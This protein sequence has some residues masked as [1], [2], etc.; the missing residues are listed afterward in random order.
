MEIKTF[1]I[2]GLKL[3]RL[4][5]FKDAR[6]FFVERYNQT[7]FQAAGLPMNFV[8]DNFSRSAPGVLRGLHFQH[9]PAQGKLVSCTSGRIFDVAVDVRKDSKT[10]GQHVTVE[11]DGAEPML[12]WIPAG[13]AHGF[14]VMGDQPA[15]VLYKVDNLWSA[16]GEGCLLW[17]DPALK[18]EWPVR[19]PNISDKD[20]VG[21]T[22]AEYL[23]NPVF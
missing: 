20:R 10:Y 11:L 17:N 5:S 12:F 1:A 23:K 22:F 14:C 4:Q 18:I 7:K 16:K 9:A 2:E 6:G 13:F 21:M 3:I 19:T 15:D 8:Q